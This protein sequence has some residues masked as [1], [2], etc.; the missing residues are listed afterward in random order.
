MIIISQT[1]YAVAPG[2]SASFFASGGTPPYTYSIIPANAAG[3]SINGVSGYYTAPSVWI[4]DAK[5]T[6]D[7]IQAVDGVGA[8]ATAKI[9]V[10]QPMILLLE[11]IQR[12]MNLPADRVYIYGQKKFEPSNAGIYIVLSHVSQKV[13]GN[14]NRM[15][16]DTLLS[17]QYLSVS[18]RIGVDV[19][20]VDE[21]A[22]WRKDE[23]LLALASDYSERQQNANGFQIGKLPVGG[24]MVAL[25]NIDGTHIPYR[26]HFDIGL[27]YAYVKT[28]AADY[29]DTFDNAEVTTNS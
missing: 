8:T 29:F 11:I 12:Q 7:T 20:S 6:F 21:S 27:Q 15:N 9:L 10:G 14:S 22:L 2:R 3:G 26:F 16:P 19:F 5:H 4:Q 23:V 25:P 13:F 1:A 28:S 17:D 24:Q 18:A